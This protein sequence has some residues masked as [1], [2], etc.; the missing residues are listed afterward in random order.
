MTPINEVLQETVT[1]QWS[2]IHWT[3][4]RAQ[5]MNSL[6]LS[7]SSSSDGADFSS[8]PGLL[9]ENGSGNYDSLGPGQRGHARALSSVSA[10]SSGMGTGPASGT[11]FRTHSRQSSL[12]SCQFHR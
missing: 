8:S 10:V 4:K 11:G 12:E 9:S 6:S 1:L 7:F 3:S 5:G 2:A